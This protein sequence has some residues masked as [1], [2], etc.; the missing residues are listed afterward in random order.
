M[1]TS[2]SEINHLPQDSLFRTRLEGLNVL[3]QT[4][5]TDSSWTYRL[6]RYKRNIRENDEV[7]VS[8]FSRNY[9]DKI[10]S[11]LDKWKNRF[12]HCIV[13]IKNILH[14]YIKCQMIIVSL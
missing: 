8:D 7:D 9:R 2:I 3:K 1:K 10:R 11:K 5:L 13:S 6:S 12:F 14:L 4:P